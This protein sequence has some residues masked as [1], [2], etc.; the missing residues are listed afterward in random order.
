MLLVLFWLQIAV[1]FV[2]CLG[3][4][5]FVIVHAAPTSALEAVG[6]VAGFGGVPALAIVLVLELVKTNNRA[7][8]RAMNG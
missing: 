4:L 2:A 6:L 7:A 5:Y 1:A 3:A 8:I